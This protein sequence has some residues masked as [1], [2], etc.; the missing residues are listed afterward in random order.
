M[1]KSPAIFFTCRS[2]VSAPEKRYNRFSK[3]RKWR[4]EFYRRER[5]LDIICEFTNEEIAL[6][7]NK[8]KHVGLPAS[9]ILAYAKNHRV[10]LHKLIQFG[11][12]L[13]LNDKSA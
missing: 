1:K 9:E 8:K 11:L 12:R 2:S 10:N 6:R 7:L 4:R 5:I 13:N 3:N